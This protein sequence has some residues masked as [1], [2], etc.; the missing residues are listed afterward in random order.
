GGE[1]TVADLVAHLLHRNGHDVERLSVWTGELEGANPL[2][3]IT[4]GF[5]TVWSFRGYALT[6]KAIANLSPDVLHVHNT[7]PLLSPSVYWA[8]HKASVPVVQT[9]HN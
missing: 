2:K 1:D 6:R 3:L 4:A 7:F 5:G 9:L 8:A